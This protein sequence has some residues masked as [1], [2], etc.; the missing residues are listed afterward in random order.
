M[1][2][3]DRLGRCVFVAAAVGLA[4]GIRG[5]FGHSIGAMYPGAVLGLAWCFVSGSSALRRRMPVIAG[6]TAAAIGAGGTMSYGILHGY[7]QADTFVNYTYGL[8]TLFC[9]GGCWGTFGGALAGLLCERKPMRT[10]EWLGLIG[11]IFLGGWLLPAVVVELI[12]FH[13]NPPRNNISVAFLGAALGQFVWLAFHDRPAGRRG[14]AYGFVG[15]GLGMAGGR[16]L[17]N[18]IRHLEA[19]GLSI[20]HWNVMEITCG[21]VGGGLFTWGM[22]GQAPPRDDDEDTA[23]RTP[24]VLAALYVLGVIPLWHLIAKV[25]ERFPKWAA[26]FASYGHADG[27]GSARLV[28][29]LLGVVCAVAAAGA[30]VWAVAIRMGI[31]WPAWAPVVLLSL[32]M[33]LFQNLTSHYFWYPR[34]DNYLNTHNYFWALFAFIAFA[35]LY[36]RP[37]RRPT[38]F[39]PEPFRPGR[40]ALR[41]LIAFGVLVA[42]AWLVNGPRT[43]TTANTRWPQWTWS[44]GPYPGSEKPAKSPSP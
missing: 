15:F 32:V 26:Q 44:S 28:V 38:P 43:M 36:V 29:I 23:L 40:L 3:L 31:R 10:G 12:G 13:V 7:A 21:A 6:L 25:P 30:I 33:L 9:Q 42:F 19:Y 24:N 37:D 18:A 5:D 20:N 4:W 17:G 11:S 8:F 1:S 27:E 39:D 35:A 2:I 34:K 22:L 14:A 16:V 41:T